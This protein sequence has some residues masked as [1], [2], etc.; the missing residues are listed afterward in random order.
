MHIIRFN[1]ATAFVI[2]FYIVF[3]S[4][5][6]DWHTVINNV[7]HEASIMYQLDWYN[8]A[9]TPFWN[10]ILVYN[11][12]LFFLSP[13]AIISLFVTFQDDKTKNL[14]TF[15]TIYTFIILACLIPYKQIFPYYIQVTWPAFIAFYAALFTWCIQLFRQ[16]ALQIRFHSYTLWLFLFANLVG[17]F[18]I[19]RTFHLPDIYLLIA[20]IP[21]MFGVYITYHA[22]LKEMRKTFIVTACILAFLGGIF[23]PLVLFLDSLKSKSNTYQLANMNAI[24]QLLQDGNDYVAGIDFIYNRNQPIN[25]MRLL[26]GPAI[27]FLRAPNEKLRRVML[28]SLDADPRVTVDTVIAALEQSR[29]K[30][31]VN[32]YRMNA[33][34]P[35]IKQYLDEHFTHFWGSI[36]L[37][38]PT[39]ASGKQVITI[40]F[41]GK[42]RIASSATNHV[43]LNGKHYAPDTMVSLAAGK[44]VSI[45]NKTYRLMLVPNNALQFNPAFSKD[46]WEI[47]TI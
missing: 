36:Y 14:R 16:P 7:F 24:Q 21:L 13:L 40:K 15:V 45:A 20:T 42:Y 6:S 19:I 41:P 11:P 29:V 9:R 2:A 12:L 31:Y 38:A 43:M 8:S 28:A 47:M 44:Q 22:C 32:N 46:N 23:C 18:Y 27:D 35:R 17:S 5:I 33:L 26:V 34:P 3:W 37:Y 25:G 30:F 1:S 10:N 39:I 4:C